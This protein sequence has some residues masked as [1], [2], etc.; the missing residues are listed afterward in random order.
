LRLPGVTPATRRALLRLCSA[1][2]DVSELP[3]GAPLPVIPVNRLNARY[4]PALA[5]AQLVLTGAS[6]EQSPGSVPATGFIFDM[7]DVFEDWLTAALRGAVEAR[8]DGSVRGQ[9]RLHLDHAERIELLPDITWWAGGQCRAVIDAK[10]KRLKGS[11]P[12][13]ADIYQMLAYCTAFGLSEGHLVYGSAGAAMQDFH[14]VG[15][16]I[17]I[18]VHGLDLN[19]PIDG[20]RDQIEKLAESVARWR[21]ADSDSLEDGVHGA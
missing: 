20:L 11:T 13:N 3:A 8:R 5:V 19:A 1:L 18:T 2:P 6:V 4:Q 14:L 21:A 15:G 12:P 17:R 10:Y 16:G 9:H 7:N